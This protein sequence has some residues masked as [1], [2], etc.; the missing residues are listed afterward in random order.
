MFIETY[1]K[2]PAHTIYNRMDATYENTLC[3]FYNTKD[4]L[5]TV[6]DW[7]VYLQT[8]E[9]Y[10]SGWNSYIVKVSKRYEDK[11]QRG[12]RV[13]GDWVV[14]VVF[15]DPTDAKNCFLDEFQKVKGINYHQGIERRLPTMSKW[16][17]TSKTSEAMLMF[18]PAV[19]EPIVIEGKANHLHSACY[20]LVR[21]LEKVEDRTE[22]IELAYSWFKVVA[23][24]YFNCNVKVNCDCGQCI[25]DGSDSVANVVLEQLP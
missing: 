7:L 24:E 3:Y 4:E 22:R 17:A 12:R 21:T 18:N 15:T 23:K 13:N 16:T 10:K 2:T 25:A 6:M 20:S 11:T 1:L 19:A 8:N 5:T 9:Y 14:L